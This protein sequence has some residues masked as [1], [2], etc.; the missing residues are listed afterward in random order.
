MRS[1]LTPTC[2]FESEGKKISNALIKRV[3]AQIHASAEPRLP[4]TLQIGA[5]DIDGVQLQGVINR[6]RVTANV[7]SVRLNRHFVSLTYFLATDSEQAQSAWETVR[8]TLTVTPEVIT[9]GTSVEGSNSP[10]SPGVTNG[11]LVS[12]PRPDYPKIARSAHAAGTVKVQVTIDENGN[13][14][15]AHAVSGHPLLQAAS[16]VAAKQAK[17]SPTKM[18][19][20]AVRV[21]GVI[22]YNFVAQ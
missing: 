16:V 4:V 8:A 9:L 22:D 11:H 2:D 17:F 15:A 3:A 1:G 12:L 13:V 5:T 10:V 18:C 19:G 6:K 20:E 7:Y 21:A 14:I